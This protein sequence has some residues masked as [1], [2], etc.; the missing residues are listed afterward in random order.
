MNLESRSCTIIV[1]KQIWRMMYRPAARIVRW[2][3]IPLSNSRLY[4]CEYSLFHPCVSRTRLREIRYASRVFR[5]YD[6]RMDFWYRVIQ[7]TTTL[8]QLYRRRQFSCPLVACWERS[9]SG[10]YLEDEIRRWRGYG[11]R[12]SKIFIFFR[13]GCVPGFLY[14]YS[15]E[16]S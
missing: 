1:S 13:L 9:R 8:F 5:V 7:P 16:R 10:L 15:F 4:T 3:R 11:W 12:I 6:D 2:P 14:G